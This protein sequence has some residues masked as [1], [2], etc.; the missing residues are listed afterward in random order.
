MSNINHFGAI[1]LRVTGS[2]NLKTTFFSLDEVN[3]DPQASI[4][5]SSTTA[6][7]PTIDANFT[8]M[9]AKLRIETT[10]ID[11]TFQISKIIVYVK[12]VGTSFPK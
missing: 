5:M 4:T 7:E 8:E 6:V 3:S 11:E 10:A 12:K 2:G 1:R 9:R